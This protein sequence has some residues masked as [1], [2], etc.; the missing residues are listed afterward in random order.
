MEF[1]RKEIPTSSYA[2]IIAAIV[3][4]FKLSPPSSNF[5]SV[6]VEMLATI[7]ASL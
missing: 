1:L 5:C 6:L 2:E 3:A 4:G 7:A